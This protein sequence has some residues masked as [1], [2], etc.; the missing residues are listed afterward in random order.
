MAPKL[1][2]VSLVCALAC[3]LLVGFAGAQDSPSA[4]GTVRA[5]SGTS[6]VWAQQAPSAGVMGQAAKKFTPIRNMFFPRY[7]G[8]AGSWGVSVPCPPVSLPA[9]RPPSLPAEGEATTGRLLG[10]WVS[11]ARPCMLTRRT[12]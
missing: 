2:A 11:L 10:T 6:D 1:C 3:G 12:S 7:A 5:T 9:R 8:T 4:N